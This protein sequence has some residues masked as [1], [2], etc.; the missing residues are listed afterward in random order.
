MVA[1]IATGEI[2][3]EVKTPSGKMRSGS[4]RESASGEADR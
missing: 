1:K 4:W 3:E 2:E